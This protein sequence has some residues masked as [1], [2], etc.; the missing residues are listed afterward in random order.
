[1]SIAHTHKKRRR[2]KKAVKVFVH[3]MHDE[4]IEV[5][6]KNERR[7]YTDTDGK[8]SHWKHD[9]KTECKYD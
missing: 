1:M 4:M 8:K 5:A 2:A 6:R 9:K 3:E 7:K